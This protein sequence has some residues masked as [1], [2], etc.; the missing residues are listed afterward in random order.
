MKTIT[1]LLITGV[2]AVP[3]SPAAAQNRNWQR[4][5]DGLADYAIALA[6]DALD[7]VA[8]ARAQSRT[9]RD[10]EQR[11]RERSRD[12]QQRARDAQR[13]A[14]DRQRGSENRYPEYTDTFSKT[15]TIG[16]NGRLELDSLSGNVDVTGGGGDEVKISATKRAH[17][18][19]EAAAR[20]TLRATD[21]VVTER[22]GSV[23]IKAEATRGR[24]NLAEVD[25]VITVPESTELTIA[26]LSGD[27]HVKHV[28]GDIHVDAKSGDVTI[29]D[30]KP[31]GIEASTISGDIHLDQVETDRLEANVTSGDIEYRGKLAKNGRYEFRSVS[32]NIRLEPDGNEGFSVD[33]S[34]FS[35]DFTSDLKL[36]LEGNSSGNRFS[37]GGRPVVF[38]GNRGNIHGMFNDGGAHIS[39][40]SLS[41][42]IAIAK[43]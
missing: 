4:D 11:Q 16:R 18:P 39:V 27:I 30:V 22:S 2:L 35:G 19:T 20:D 5:L 7:E 1:G 3:A 33:A 32:G 25:Y 31:R 40:R 10:A 41:G 42:D 14:G 21:I 36:T 24:Q 15:V 26:T 37:A 8:D 34:T 6:A 13:R 9:D 28:A 29:T 23:S 43:K 38:P 17:A 12:A